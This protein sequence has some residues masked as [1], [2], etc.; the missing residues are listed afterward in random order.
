MTG[1]RVKTPDFDKISR[2]TKAFSAATESR[3][4]G[5]FPLGLL[6]WIRDMGW[7][8]ERRIHLCAGGVIDPP[9]DKVDY[10]PE[11][12][13]ELSGVGRRT[14]K[15]TAN[16]IADA[17]ETGLPSESYD[18]A[19]VDPPYSSDLAESLYDSKEMFSG[20]DKF[21]KEAYRLIKP[22]GY[23]ITFS[24]AVP[25]RPAKDAEMVAMWGIY[26]IPIVRHMTCLCVFKKP[27][28]RYEMGLRRWTP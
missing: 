22:G 8:G 13:E 27:G 14:T 21:A 23:C 11:L 18:W 10:R 16:I 19:M 24:Y 17:R 3:Y 15:S 26:Q 20:I 4:P 6:D 7:W 5:S 9:A 28:F 12:P 1:T 2:G 25:N